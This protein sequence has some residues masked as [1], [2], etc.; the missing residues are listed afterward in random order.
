[1]RF[2]N[3]KVKGLQWPKF[4]AKERAQRSHPWIMLL[5]IVCSH[6]TPL[7]ATDRW[8]LVDT[9]ALTLTVMDGGSTV[10][11]FSEISLG[12][13]GVTRHKVRGDSRTPLGAYQISEVREKSDF[14]RF[15][16]IDFPRI[17]DA[18]KAL[19][20]GTIDEAEFQQIL[21]AHEYGLQP[22]WNTPMGGNIGIHGVGSGDPDVHRNFNWTDG[23]IALTN[24]QIDELT[25]LIRPGMTVV[26][27]GVSP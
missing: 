24:D 7:F 15:I 21:H 12:R 9:N 1:M 23:C 10:A 16:A 3:L 5:M 18:Q 8:I 22:P 19:K 17:P 14:H 26:I 20:E 25:P 2:K 13:N 6:H 11:A 4:H 27:T